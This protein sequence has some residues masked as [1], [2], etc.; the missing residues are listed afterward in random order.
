MR[1]QSGGGGEQCT[2]DLHNHLALVTHQINIAKLY[3][4][5]GKNNNVTLNKECYGSSP[6]ITTNTP[7]QGCRGDHPASAGIVKTPNQ[8][9]GGGYVI[10]LTIDEGWRRG[11]GTKI[12]TTSPTQTKVQM[13]G[14]CIREWHCTISKT[15]TQGVCQID[16]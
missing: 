6:T 5:S 3:Q 10:G 8:E 9:D 1:R 12:I 15:F 14:Y 11:D 7:G 16:R 2:F 4:Q 13:G